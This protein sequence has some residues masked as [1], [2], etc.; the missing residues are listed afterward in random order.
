MTGKI[1]LTEG[2]KEKI[3][4]E[5][6]AYAYKLLKEPEKDISKDLRANGTGK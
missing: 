1:H 3:R 5:A 2:E 4:C 6:H